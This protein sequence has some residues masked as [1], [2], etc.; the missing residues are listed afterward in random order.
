MT[1]AACGRG[2]TRLSTTTI[3]LE[4]GPGSIIFRGV[5]ANVCQS[6]GEEFVED[7]VALELIKR[8]QAAAASG[9]NQ[10]TLDYAAG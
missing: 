7:R 3:V 4:N 10:Q 8:T 9:A 6:C 5:P 1:C 2:E